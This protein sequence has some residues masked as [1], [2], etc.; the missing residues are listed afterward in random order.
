[1]RRVLGRVPGAARARPAALDPRD[2]PRSAS[3]TGSPGWR[4]RPASSPCSRCRRWCS[5]W[6]VA[7]GYLGKLARRRHRSTQVKDRI[8]DVSAQVLTAGQRQRGHQAHAATTSFD[9]GRFDLIS[10]GFVLAL[11]SGSRALNV[12]IDTISIMYGL[13]G[14]RGIVRTRVLSFTL[15]VVALARRRRSSIPLVLAGPTLL[16]EVLPDQVD[17]LDSLYWPVASLLSVVSPHHAVPRQR[18]RCGR[19][20][21]R[22]ARRRCSP[23]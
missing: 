8:I 2:H 1:M 18:R 21:A 3:A 14:R 23:W 19:R 20:G 10:I 9:G 22:P 13:G 6:S 16:G 12:F 4:P 15:Y 5:G 17:F 7:I 11:W